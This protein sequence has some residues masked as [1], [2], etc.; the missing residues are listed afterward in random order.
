MEKTIKKVIFALLVCN[1]AVA[2]SVFADLAK[3]P[4]TTIVKSDARISTPA[5]VKAPQAEALTRIK[6][7]A[8]IIKNASI[9]D[10]PMKKAKVKAFLAELKNI[11]VDLGYTKRGVLSSVVLSSFLGLVLGLAMRHKY[12]VIKLPLFLKVPLMGAYF[13]YCYKLGGAIENDLHWRRLLKMNS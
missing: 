9:I 10:T 4:V 12:G 3:T 11:Y 1:I 2:S 5:E 7:N 6:T 13:G 8:S